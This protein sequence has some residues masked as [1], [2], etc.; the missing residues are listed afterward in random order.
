MA[1]PHCNVTYTS[2]GYRNGNCSEHAVCNDTSIFLSFSF[3]VSKLAV[4]CTCRQGFHGNGTWCQENFDP[5]ASKNGGCDLQRATCTYIV[6]KVTDMIQESA[7]CQC[8]QGYAGDG[9]VCSTD[10]IDAMARIWELRYLYSWLQANDMLNTTNATQLMGDGKAR[11]TAFLPVST[12]W[13]SL[14][15]SQLV[16]DGVVFRLP[17][18]QDTKDD[19]SQDDKGNA[20]DS[21]I[22]GHL[23]SLSG[24]LIKITQNDR[25][26]FFANDVKIVQGN[27]ESFNGVLHLTESPIAKYLCIVVSTPYCNHRV[28]VPS[29]YT[30]QRINS[31]VVIVCVVV[32]VVVVVI[33][34]VGAGV[35]IK[36]HHE[37][38]LKIFQRSD[39]NSESNI[40]FARLS[41][42]E[43]ED[44]AFKAPENARY[45]NPIFN[46]PDVM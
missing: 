6:P 28:K 25:K 14:D 26:E 20:T 44:D 40:S 41:A 12:E 11:S 17:S 13:Q 15:L 34:L 31:T 45:D 39:S 29:E 30:D 10:L 19:A 36:K 38:I 7:G 1:L 2:C 3:Q 35:Y 27:I 37:G 8:K 18:Y 24:Q 33:A 43:E 9:R 46:D 16:V 21:N 4:E 42:N 23:V 22:L 5:C 32:A